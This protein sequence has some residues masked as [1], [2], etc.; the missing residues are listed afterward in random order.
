MERNEHARRS[1]RRFV[2][3]LIGSAALLALDAA[4]PLGLAV[5]LFQVVLMWIT[6][7]WASRQQ[8]LA[9]AFLC[10]ASIVLAF[11]LSTKAESEYWIGIMNVLSG[12]SAAWAIAHNSIRHLAAEEARRKAAE[13]VDRS[14]AQ[15]K[16]LTGLLPICSACKKIRNETGDWEQLESYITD[17]SHA[18]FSHSL[19]PPCIARLYPDLAEPSRPAERRCE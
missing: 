3:T 1:Q 14:E 10:S 7:L 18:Q 13:Q 5:W 8:I 2:L 15:I 4:T 19:C 17:R 16:V 11:C 12:V 6:T 9:V